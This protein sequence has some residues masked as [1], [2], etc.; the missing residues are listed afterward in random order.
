MSEPGK[1]NS[2][3]KTLNLILLFTTGLVGLSTLVIIL[4]SL[5]LGMWLDKLNASQPAFTMGL[6]L[7]SIPIS[8]I[9][10]IFIVKG[11]INRFKKMSESISEE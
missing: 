6:L 4:G 2:K 3:Q 5:F 8:L 7:A 10:M 1:T 11:L 9:V